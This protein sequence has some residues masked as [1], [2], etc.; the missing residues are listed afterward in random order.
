MVVVDQRRDSKAELEIA[1]VKDE[2][3]LLA[4]AEEVE[5]EE[6]EVVV[7]LEVIV[8]VLVVLES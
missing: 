4:S 2:L 5:T 1:E 6:T 7:R 3:M 8:G